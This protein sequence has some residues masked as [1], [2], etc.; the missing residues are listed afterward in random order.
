MVRVRAIGDPEDKC[1]FC[2]GCVVSRSFV[3]CPGG[4]GRRGVHV[5]VICGVA[6]VDVMCG[7][8]IVLCGAVY[9]LWAVGL[10]W[11]LVWHAVATQAPMPHKVLL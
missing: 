2:T 10:A 4:D 8:E 9:V 1:G 11:W 6:P 5:V 3:S 7:E